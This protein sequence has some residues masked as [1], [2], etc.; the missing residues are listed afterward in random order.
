[1]GND[2]KEHPMRIDP[3]SHR[4]ASAFAV[5]CTSGLIVSCG[6]DGSTPSD[7][8]TDKPSV[9]VDSVLVED[10]TPVVGTEPVGQPANP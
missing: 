3:R 10:T 7:N 1:V 4:L 2:L 6:S 5:L 9:V 8:S